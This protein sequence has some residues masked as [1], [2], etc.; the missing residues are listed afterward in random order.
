MGSCSGRCLA[1]PSY[2]PRTALSLGVDPAV[3][4][5][6]QNYCGT[7]F[8]K[9]CSECKHNVVNTACPGGRAVGEKSVIPDYVACEEFVGKFEIDRI[10]DSERRGSV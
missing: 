9:K 7:L 1:C 8:A 4:E 10:S 6:R 3:V 5:A 2:S